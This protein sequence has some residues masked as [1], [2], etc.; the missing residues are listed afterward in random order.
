MANRQWQGKTGGGN[1]G[2][3]FLFFTLRRIPVRMMYWVLYLTTPFYV[4]FTPKNRRHIY[5][6]YHQ[7]QGF[8]AWK[9]FWRV[10]VNYL[11]FGK[12]VM[13]KFAMM[14]GNTKQF[15]IASVE[16]IEQFNTLLDQPQGFIL[17]SA[18]VGNFELVGHCLVQNQKRVNGI[19]F[20][21]ESAQMQRQREKSSAEWNIRLIPVTDAISHVFAVKN[22]LDNGEIV[23]E[24]CD[25]MF[26]SEKGFPATL[27][28]A[29]TQLPAGTF[30]LAVQLNVPIVTLFIMKEHGT[31]YRGYLST[32]QHDSS[33]P[34]MAQAKNLAQQFATQLETI[35]HRY[36]NQWF[37][38]FD[39]WGSNKETDNKSNHEST[40][41]PK[42][43]H[44][45]NP[46][47]AKR[48]VATAVWLPHKRSDGDKRNII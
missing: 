22:A 37:N 34:A 39:F 31:T 6:Y 30:R 36:P 21:G 23:T 7:R 11:V 16:N 14:A 43:H 15:R 4:L 18:H 42:R 45:N 13:D 29:E 38:Y 41:V 27:L 20:G 32:L 25:R 44:S 2:Q 17:A 35:M 3:N 40:I 19:I 33:L 28:G 46:S 9:S 5:N 8:G 24:L 1:F 47:Q 26:G 12:V 48:S 10:F